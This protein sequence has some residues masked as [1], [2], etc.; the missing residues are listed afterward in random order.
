[1]PPSKQ[2]QGKHRGSDEQLNRDREERTEHLAEDDLVVAHVGQ[3]KQHERSP[4]LLLRHWRRPRR[5][6]EEQRQQQLDEGDD[7]E[8][9]AA[10]K[11]RSRRAWRRGEPDGRLPGGDAED[12]SSPIR[13][14][15][16]RVVA[17]APGHGHQFPHEDRTEHARLLQEAVELR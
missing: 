9:Q 11:R 5:S 4:V 1:M 7:L 6:C 13:R 10:R 17:G 3:E 2:Q 16:A 12:A 14:G 15:P 8:Q